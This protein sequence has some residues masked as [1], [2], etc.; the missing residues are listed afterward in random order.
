MNGAR[1][2]GGVTEHFERFGVPEWVIKTYCKL[3]VR[4]RSAIHDG[5]ASLRYVRGLDRKLEG[6]YWTNRLTRGEMDL[7]FDSR[8]VADSF[9]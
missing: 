6:E 8:Q 1:E 7:K 4:E 9:R 3:G 2:S 5:A